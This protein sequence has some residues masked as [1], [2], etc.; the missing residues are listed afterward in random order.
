MMTK[1][2]ELQVVLKENNNLMITKKISVIIYL[3]CIELGINIFLMQLLII[4]M[5]LFAMRPIAK[6]QDISASWT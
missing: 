4:S 5:T 6:W 3:H 2:H 1:N